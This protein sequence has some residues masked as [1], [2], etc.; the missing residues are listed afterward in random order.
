VQQIDL[1]LS[2][3]E[4]PSGDGFWLCAQIKQDE[5]F[6]HVPVF[7]ATSLDSHES[8]R[9]GFA[10]GADDYLTKP[11]LLPEL[12]TR[13]HRA[14]SPVEKRR[15][16]RVLVVDDSQVVRE[17]VA[18]LLEAHG[19]DVEGVGDGA[20]A[21]DVLA[22]QEIQLVVSDHDMPRVNG[23]ELCRAI[24]T[25]DRTRTLP[26]IMMSAI[27]SQADAV[28]VRSAGVNTFIKKPFTSDRML[29]E[30]ERALAHTMLAQQREAM[31]HY[32]S[33]DALAAVDRQARS[34][35]GEMNRASD[36]HRT[37][38]FT[39]I[40]GFTSLC[41]R[42]AAREM[43][44]LLNI[45]FERMVEIAVRWGASVDKFIGDALMVLFD[46]EAQGACRAICAGLEMLDALPEISQ[47]VGHELHIRVGINSGHVV[48]GD[49]GSRLHRRD[50]T[51]IGDSVNLAQRL[52]SAAG[53]DQIYISQPT[54]DL[55]AD[56]VEAV[57]TRLLKVK[58]KEQPVQA[59][60]I[61]G[62]AASLRKDFDP[63]KGRGRL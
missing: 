39:D 18:R 47:E 6:R 23:I 14:L 58:G 46:E 24:R 62:V 31:R 32:M 27:V 35:T 12:L 42:L 3:V 61:V 8:I 43:V 10:A 1:V 5:L 16:K 49:I 51:V 37:I 19:F 7:L 41:E 38:L 26:F 45:Y 9:K 15:S 28:K 36:Q 30:V 33:S 22:T 52:E 17:M 57:P 13:V 2:D 55:V 48:Q 25:N 11:I 4:M 21:L 34:G 60:R 63:T 29:V 20:D 54:H 56:W 44:D 40:V 59:Y 50:F 53:R